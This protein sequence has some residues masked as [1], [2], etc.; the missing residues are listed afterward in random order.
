VPT[1]SL[2]KVSGTVSCRKG[3]W[4]VL[5]LLSS[6]P[7]SSILSGD[8]STLKAPK[9]APASLVEFLTVPLSSHDPVAALQNSIF[10][11]RAA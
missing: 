7:S 5:T 9:T 1:L 8:D 3:T 4:S 10:P 6:D 11:V 2:Q